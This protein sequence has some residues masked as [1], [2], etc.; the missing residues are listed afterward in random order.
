MQG[1]GI[2]SLIS[3]EEGREVA[4]FHADA[5]GSTRT[6]TDDTESPTA[7]YTYDAWGKL[8]DSTGDRRETS[9]PLI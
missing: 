5:L 3:R 2:D 6:M 1:V 4:Y 8:T 7:T 9:P